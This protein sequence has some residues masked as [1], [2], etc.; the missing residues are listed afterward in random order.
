MSRIEKKA[1]GKLRGS[2]KRGELRKGKFFGKDRVL[3]VTTFRG[4]INYVHEKI[5]NKWL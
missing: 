1:L 3:T 5:R 4:Y 2:L